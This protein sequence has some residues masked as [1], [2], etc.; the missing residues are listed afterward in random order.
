MMIYNHNPRSQEVAARGSEVDDHSWVQ[1]DSKTS[2]GYI[3]TLSLENKGWKTRSE[4]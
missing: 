1:I 3:K 4:P 2:R